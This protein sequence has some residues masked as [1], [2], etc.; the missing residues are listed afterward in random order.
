[1]FHSDTI[2]ENDGSPDKHVEIM[3]SAAHTYGNAIAFIE[4]WLIN[5]FPKDFFKTIHVNSKIAHRQI[6]NTSHEY[7]KK[8]KPIFALTPRVDFDDARFLEGTPLIERRTNLYTK[9]PMNSLMPFISDPKRNLYVRYQLNR[10][11]MYA[12]VTLILNTKME[13]LNYA[14]YLQN[15]T[16]WN[17]P[18]NLS[19]CFESY[20]GTE[21]IEEISDLSG[22]PIVDTTGTTHTFL[23]YLNSHSQFPVTYKL[24]G[25]RNKKEFYRYYPVTV[26]TLLSSLNIDD[27]ERSGQINTNYKITFIVRME[28]FSTGFYF[29]FS[30]DVKPIVPLNVSDNDVIIPIYTDVMLKE[31]LNLD[32]GWDLFTS[33]SF[34]LEDRK[35]SVNFEEILN[36]SIKEAIK[37]HL[38]NGLPLID[39]IDI[40]IRRQGNL[41]FENADYVINWDKF[42]VDIED[43]DYLYYTYTMYVSININYLNNLLKDLFNIKRFEDTKN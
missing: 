40:K 6:R 43:K 28:F 17:I 25:A 24:D 19:T 9:I 34:Q 42:T 23:Q 37:Y 4:N 41:L 3:S 31:D 35:D 18:Q 12:D 27:G 7:N 5:L 36:I 10:T 13:Q 21:L 2:I 15:A 30:N 39:L 26:D 38:R 32:N 11:V 1:M 33:V 22:I 8:L 14:S 20:I 29:L 16:I